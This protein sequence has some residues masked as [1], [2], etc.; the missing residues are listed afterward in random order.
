MK[1]VSTR[2]AVA[3]LILGMA[4]P[5]QAGAGECG[6]SCCIGAGIDGVGSSTGLSVSLQY[7]TMLM[8]TNKQGSSTVAPTTIIANNLAARGMMSM[9]SVSTKMTMQKITANIVYRMD[10]NNA[11]LLAAPYV[12]ND[13]EMLMGMKG[14]GGITYSTIT[15]NTIRGVGDLS[16]TW[17]RDIYKDADYVPASASPPASVSRRRP[18]NTGRA[19]VP[20]R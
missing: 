20:V 4:L 16:L 13:M 12:I 1:C 3:A 6:L 15:M 10:E 19:T 7:D 14:M 9:Y 5:M 17:L 18:A 2:A 11:F 8:K